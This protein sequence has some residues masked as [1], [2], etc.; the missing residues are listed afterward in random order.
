MMSKVNDTELLEV[1]FKSKELL[2]SAFTQP[3]ISALTARPGR[4]AAN[5]ALDVTLDW[6]NSCRKK[7]PAIKEQH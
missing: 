3:H 7:S 4:D 1:S 5:T 6:A 2:K